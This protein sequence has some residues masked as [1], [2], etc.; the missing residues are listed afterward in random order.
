MTSPES[1]TIKSMVS[2]ATGIVDQSRY[3]SYGH[4][5]A[6][7]P[8][9]IDSPGK[10]IRWDL[11]FHQKFLRGHHWTG[12]K[13]QNNQVP[14]SLPRSIRTLSSS[15]CERF[16]ASKILYMR[17]LKFEFW[18]RNVVFWNDFWESSSHICVYEEMPICFDSV[19][20]VVEWFDSE[21][22]NICESLRV[23]FLFWLGYVWIVQTPHG[24]DA[25][26]C[27]WSLYNSS[28]LLCLC[29]HLYQKS[30]R[31]KPSFYGSKPPK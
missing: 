2:L 27:F 10:G 8:R 9:K 1:T 16:L 18:A 11:G 29:L 17:E 3:G 15:P 20:I 31:V 12:R 19:L 13:G 14:Y 6:H 21:S 23:S 28:C 25:V 24:R 7:A 5:P 30:W 22:R 4:R 26:W